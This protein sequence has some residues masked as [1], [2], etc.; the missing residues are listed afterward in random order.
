MAAQD[1]PCELAALIAGAAAALP[2]AQARID[3]AAAP[4]AMR[5]AGS[6]ELLAAV[7]PPTVAR[8]DRA[9]ISLGLLATTD[10]RVAASLAAWPLSIGLRVLHGLA[11]AEAARIT[12]GIQAAPRR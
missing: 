3:R 9:T 6:A 11:D 7:G 2:Q 1:L 4:A 12:I 10:R 5:H 8:I